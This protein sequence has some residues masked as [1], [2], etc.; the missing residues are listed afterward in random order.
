MSYSAWIRAWPCMPTPALQA[1]HLNETLHKHCEYHA[2]PTSQVEPEAQEVQAWRQW[3][4]Q[5]LALRQGDI[6]AESPDWHLDGVGASG[7]C[8]LVSSAAA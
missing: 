3:P 7:M 8:D 6:N 2:M 4:A 1:Q 5:W